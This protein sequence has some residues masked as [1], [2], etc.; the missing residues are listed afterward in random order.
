VEEETVEMVADARATDGQIYFFFRSTLH[1]HPTPS[2]PK[3]WLQMEASL[4]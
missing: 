1:S 3:G 4:L 2:G